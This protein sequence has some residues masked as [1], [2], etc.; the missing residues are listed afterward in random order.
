VNWKELP[1]PFATESARNN[2][3]IVPRPEGAQLSAPS[4]FTVE[5][6]LTG[7]NRP[8]FMILGPGNEILLSETA[9]NGAV[10][11]IKEGVKTPII[12][13]L[14]RPYG[15]ALQG[16]WLY[17]AEP[18]AVKRYRYDARTMRVVGEGERI[19]AM[20]GMG[21]GHTTR[22]LLFSRDGKKLYL[23]VGSRSNIDLGEPE[24]RAALHRYN[25]DGT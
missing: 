25:L 3:T 14:D 22:T 5:P 16:E 20:D 18:E 2:P 1:A 9:R 10:S 15:L 6:F 7:L 8:R 11:V 23:S 24:L 21:T 12:E 13:K 17:V 4:G 19:V